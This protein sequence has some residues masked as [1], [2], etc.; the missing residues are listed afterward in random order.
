MGGGLHREWPTRI[1]AKGQSKS[2]LIRYYFTRRFQYDEIAML[3]FREHVVRMSVRTLIRRLSILGLRRR[4][5][6]YDFELVRTEIR[7]LMDGLNSFRGY[8][9]IVAPT[10]NARYFSPKEPSGKSDE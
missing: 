3:M 6:Q 8:R 9:A 2:E 5:D 7:T 1:D 4:H 10:P